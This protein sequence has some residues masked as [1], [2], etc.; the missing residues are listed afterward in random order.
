[1]NDNLAEIAEN[2]AKPCQKASQPSQAPN[3][4]RDWHGTRGRKVSRPLQGSLGMGG[5]LSQG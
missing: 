5:L 2:L 4:Y 3:L 1:M